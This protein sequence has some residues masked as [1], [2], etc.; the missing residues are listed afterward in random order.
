MTKPYQR[1]SESGVRL[2]NTRSLDGAPPSLNAEAQF[3]WA[4]TANGVTMPGWK[5]KLAHAEQAT[6]SFSAFSTTCESTPGYLWR[7]GWIDHNHVPVFERECVNTGDFDQNDYRGN[8][9]Q[10]F[11]DYEAISIAAS[12][13]YEKAHDA[14]VALEGGELLGEIGQTVQEIKRLAGDATSLFSDW[15]R[16]IKRARKIKKTGRALAGVLSDAYLRWKFG[17]DPLV[18][19]VKALANDLKDD[20]IEVQTIKAQGKS[21]YVSS[22]EDLANNLNTLMPL[23]ASRK[24]FEETSVRHK[25]GVIL[26]RYGVGGLAETLGLSPSNFLPTV[27]NLLPWTYMI[28]YFSNLGSIVN[29]IAFQDARFAWVSSTTRRTGHVEIISGFNPAKTPPGIPDWDDVAGSPITIPSRILWT[30]KSVIRTQNVPE[31]PQFRLKLPNFAS[32]GG[33]IQGANIIAVLSSMTWGS[34]EMSRFRN[35]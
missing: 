13:F 33:A 5:Y 22:V 18:K 23:R 35:G 14:I 1:Y 10:G 19:D 9:H 29:A 11:S 3:S 24:R 30:S 28:D 6:T 34:K 32:T 4:N 21:T 2:E 26:K 15:R 31:V 17:W 8:L 7:K 16:T 12:Q 27:Y 25:A 20:F